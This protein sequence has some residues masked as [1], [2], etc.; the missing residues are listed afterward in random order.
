[1]KKDLAASLLAVVGSVPAL[2]APQTSY[3]GNVGYYISQ[4]SNSPGTC[5]SPES[6]IVAAGHTAVRITNLDAASL[7]PLDALIFAT[8]FSYAGD[9]DVDAAV[10]NGMA[11]VIDTTFN[12]NHR[13]LPG[14]PAFSVN[15]NCKRD[16]DLA[17]GSPIASGAGGA[18]TNSSF[19]VSGADQYCSLTGSVIPSQLPGSSVP[20]IV[21]PSTGQFSSFGYQH[22]L[23][24]IAVSISSF[25]LGD[26]LSS[27]SWYPATRIYFS[28]ALTWALQNRFTSCKAEGLSGPKLTMCQQICEIPQSPT[29]LS[30]WIKMYITAYR[31]DPPC[32]N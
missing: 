26:Y 21:E 28:N 5:T 4:Y 8:C 24:R 10:A 18:L 19:D 15:F 6:S 30:A 7:A 2:M 25:S 14:A 17:P 22:G 16:N 27:E 29:R 11:L 1:M 9:P 31:E 13:L 3:A 12:F 23:G 32:A 20:F